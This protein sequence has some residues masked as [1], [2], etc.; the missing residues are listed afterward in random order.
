MKTVKKI[1]FLNIGFA[2]PG[3]KKYRVLH[4]LWTYLVLFAASCA[5]TLL[6]LG[7]AAS[8]FGLPM[9]V[10]YFK[11][12]LIALL[13]ALPVMLLMLFFWFA[14]G[15]AWIAVLVTG[16]VTLVA[17]TGNWYKLAL[18]DDPFMFADLKNLAAAAQITGRY[19]LSPD[20][21][22]ICAFVGL[23]LLTLFC[24]LLARARHRRAP[25]LRVIGA[26]CAVL[27]AATL[28]CTVYRSSSVYS[29]TAN[30]ALINIWSSTQQYVSRGFFYPFI[31]SAQDAFL[32]APE[33]YD[34][35]A[36]EAMLAEYDNDDAAAPK[37]S[38]LAV[39]LE[40]YNDFSAFEGLEV[41]ADVYENF[42][43]FQAD[44]LSGRLWTSIFAGGTVET[45]WMFL[46][47]FENASAYSYRSALNSYVRYFSALG[48]TTQ[49]SHPG[50]G[51]FYNRRNVNGYLGFDEYYFNENLYAELWPQ[52]VVTPDS[53]LFPQILSLFEAAEKPVFSFNVTYQNHGPYDS[54]STGEESHIACSGLSNEAYNIINN[55]LSG[56]A[57][58]D[59][60]L[61]EL[62]DA[63]E[64]TDEP[65]VLLLFG[66]H[67]P[68]LGDG[69][70]VYD[71]LGISLDADTEEGAANYYC[72]PYVIWAN[73]AAEEALGRR[74]H[75]DGGDFSPNFLMNR[76][77]EAIGL[78]GDAFMQLTEALYDAGV[79]V[80]NNEG[81][82]VVDGERCDSLEGDALALY[83]QMQH[84]QYYRTKNP[85]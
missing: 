42:H 23:V 81:W 67:N 83:T 25:W 66:D 29:A 82:F 27:T 37:V 6:Q 31:H 43:S 69:S 26:A 79:S 59:A 76:L 84:A 64:A 30:T 71:E 40:A 51:W 41:D 7:L 10:S 80:I 20:W 3:Y 12:P 5:L 78:E 8:D 62:R 65:V 74:L 44:G 57:E 61:G 72:T 19:S 22:V 70:F 21:Q 38:V 4:F 36:T 32:P 2:A 39:M 55:Y 14:A 50:Y 47:G 45:E 49:G 48:Y 46:T 68:W 85:Y 11:N 54:G 1:L 9:L 18:R 13:N 77:F 56:I 75:G 60:A 53:I 16:L 52:D 58:T 17:A 63:L 15:R 24:A 73:A 33:G 34:E 28:F 35:Q